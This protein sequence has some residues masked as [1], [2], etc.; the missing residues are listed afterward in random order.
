MDIPCAVCQDHSSGKHYGVYVCDGCAGF[1][2]RSV[3][4]DRR[5]ACKSQK[6]GNCVVDKA[7]RNLCRACRLAKCLDV[8]MNKDC[9]F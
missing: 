6:P 7:H 5:Y 8:G 3:R 1:F 4:S 2:K 9:K